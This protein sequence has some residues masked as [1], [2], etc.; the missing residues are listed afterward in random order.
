MIAEQVAAE[1]QALLM[2]T[3]ELLRSGVQPASVGV[4]VQAAAMLLELNRQQVLRAADCHVPLFGF[5]CG[6]ELL[7]KAFESSDVSQGRDQRLEIFLANR[8]RLSAMPYTGMHA[9]L[10]LGRAFVDVL[11]GTCFS[12]ISRAASSGCKLIALQV[13]SPYLFHGGKNLGMQTSQ[14]TQLAIVNGNTSPA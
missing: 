3:W 6:P 5:G 10:G 14:R 12:A 13:R 2:Q 4:Q 9:M 7:A 8:W 1:N 11:H